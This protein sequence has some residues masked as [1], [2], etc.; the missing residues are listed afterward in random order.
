M[1]LRPLGRTFRQDF[2]NKPQIGRKMQSGEVVVKNSDLVTCLN[3]DRM[4]KLQPFVDV[5]Y[6]RF[7]F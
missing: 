1:T 6:K 3:C 4:C 7:F 5:Q 2:S